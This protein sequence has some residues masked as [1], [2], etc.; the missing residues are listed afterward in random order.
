MKEENHFL[1]QNAK[2]EEEVT[3]L[4]NQRLV[5]EVKHVRETAPRIAMEN[6]R[7][8]K[9]KRCEELTRQKSEAME[10]KKREDEKERLERED[11]IRQIKALERVP[12]SQVA[13]FDPTKSSGVGLLEELSL[14]ELR[15]RLASVKVLI[16]RRRGAAGWGGGKIV[17]HM[18]GVCV[19]D[20]FA[21][22]TQE[23]D[24]EK[25]DDRRSN[26]IREKEEKRMEIMNRMQNLAR[27][28]GSSSITA[29]KHLDENLTNLNIVL[30]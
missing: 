12:K 22:T 14:A 2:R 30:F 11:K 26:I 1:L 13:E 20:L 27:I 4:L 23:R 15:E 25:E 21:L 7:I 3:V 24:R 9:I 10:N 5:G 28:R 16:E 6:V 29:Y 18:L 17:L 19:L 8:E